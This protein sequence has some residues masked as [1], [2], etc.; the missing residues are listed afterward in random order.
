MITQTSQMPLPYRGTSLPS[1]QIAGPAPSSGGGDTLERA[2]QE[3]AFDPKTLALSLKAQDDW[4]IGEG[5]EMMI[6]GLLGLAIGVG[7]GSVG[8]AAVS[9]ALKASTAVV[10]AS[11]IGGGLVGGLAGG[12]LG[13]AYAAHNGN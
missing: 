9:S 5:I 11:A 3:P 1:L 8:G 6:Y 13:A 12:S 2:S 4:G 10:T 7:L